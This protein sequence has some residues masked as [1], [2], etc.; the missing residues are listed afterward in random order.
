MDTKPSLPVKMGICIPVDI[1]K[2]GATVP[3]I[4]IHVEMRE[5]HEDDEFPIL[6]PEIDYRSVRKV[7]VG[8]DEFSGMKPGRLYSRFADGHNCFRVR[9]NDPVAGE[10][11]AEL[12]IQEVKTWFMLACDHDDKIPKKSFLTDLFD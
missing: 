3:C 6:V 9:L 1:Q 10:F 2:D 12:S 5:G 4:G 11:V 8:K 7:D